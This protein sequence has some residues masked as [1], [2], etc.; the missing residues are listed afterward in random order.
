MDEREVLLKLK[1]ILEAERR[2]VKKEV[3]KREAF[4]GKLL[5]AKK[6]IGIIKTKKLQE[7]T[8]L[9]FI[10]NDAVNELGYVIRSGRYHILR[11]TDTPE[12]EMLRLVELENLISYDLQ[13]N[14]IDYYLEAE[15]P[16]VADTDFDGKIEG[17]DEYQSKAAITSLNLEDN[18]LLLVIGPPGTGKTTFISKTAEMAAERG[19]RVLI[20]SHTNRAVDNAIGK[21]NMNGV[22]RVG[23][24]S[25]ISP[26]IH[27]CSLEKKVLNKIHFEE[28]ENAEEML[29]YLSE[30]S[31]QIEHEMIKM[32]NSAIIVGSTLIKSAIFPM[33]EQNFDLVFI[34]ESSQSLIS[35]A[36]LA[37]Q[38]GRRYVLVGDPYQL[39]PVLKLRMDSSKFSA[40]NFFHSIKPHVLWLRNHYRSNAKIIGFSEKYIYK[41]QIK[42][43]EKC[44]NIKLEI[45]TENAVLSPDKPIVFL[46]VDGIEEGSGS[47]FNRKEA[48]LAVKLCDE[49]LKCGVRKEDIGIITPYVKQKELIGKMTDIEVNTVDGFQGREKDVIIFSVTAVSNLSFASNLR[50]LNVAVTRAK[51]KL[52]VIGNEKSFMIPGNRT[53]LI[54]YLYKYAKNDDAVFYSND[55]TNL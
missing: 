50:R 20:T 10:E 14:I 12:T 4:S 42:A 38:K 54:Y 9:G 22:V 39:S 43:H 11:M 37:I 30:K 18:Q 28:K 8:L 21:L 24:P 47:K 44:K 51:K 36:L 41:R 7:G 32:L 33:N 48:E 25:K 6:G 2:M 29:D 46:S 3:D 53:K 16:R 40:F 15:L 34:D 49:L 19:M 1:E 26:E 55:L 27:K 31:K 17:L 45:S 23:N 13:I 5:A 35:A 52:I